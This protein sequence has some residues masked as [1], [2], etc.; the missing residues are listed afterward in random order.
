VPSFSPLL[1]THLNT[2]NTDDINMP[3]SSAVGH[4]FKYLV[5]EKIEGAL[6]KMFLLCDVVFLV[7]I[8]EKLDQ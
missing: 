7:C 6:I 4:T 3:E 2:T 8:V 5:P 1:P